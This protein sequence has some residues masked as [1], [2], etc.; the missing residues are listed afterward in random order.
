MIVYEENK[1]YHMWWYA[2]DEESRKV[3]EMVVVVMGS[4]GA[5]AKTKILRW[6]TFLYLLVPWKHVP[7]CRSD[8]KAADQELPYLRLPYLR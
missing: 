5:I 6:L 2:G 4:S 8:A 1:E 7:I 3:L